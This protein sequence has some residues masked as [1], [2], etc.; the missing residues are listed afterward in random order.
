MH[1]PIDADLL[2]EELARLLELERHEREPEDLALTE[3]SSLSSSS[4]S[5]PEAI[6]LPA[7]SVLE[8]MLDL[9]LLGDVAALRDELNELSQQD[10]QLTPFVN[11]MLRLVQG[12]KIN[13]ICNLLEEYLK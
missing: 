1:K 4:S 5:A 9:A 3:P 7:P 2:L 11:Q 8:S 10:E 13:Q 6:H 12:F